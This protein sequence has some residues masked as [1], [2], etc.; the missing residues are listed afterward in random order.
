MTETPET[1]I[2]NGTVYHVLETVKAGELAIRNGYP[3]EYV[4]IRRPNGSRHYLAERLPDS[5]LY[6]GNRGRIVPGISVR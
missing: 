6:G 5:P 3:R 4:V 1:V 2:C